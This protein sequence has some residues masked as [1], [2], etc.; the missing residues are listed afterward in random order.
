VVLTKEGSSQHKRVVLRLRAAPATQVAT[1]LQQFFAAEI[2]Q[3]N[4]T[5]SE[6][7]G[8][9]GKGPLTREVAIAAEPISNSLLLGGPADA[10]EQVAKLVEQLDQPPAMVMLEVVLGE[11]P[12]DVLSMK[13]TAET[14]PAANSAMRRLME[15]PERMEVVSRARLVTLDNQPA[16][17]EI[18]RVEG[19]ITGITTT[20]FGQ[21]N[22]VTSRNVGTKVQC[23]PRVGDDGR[24][25]M[26]IDVS[27]S[28]LGAPGEGVVIATPKTG[29]PIRAP[30]TEQF[31]ALTTLCVPSGQT[32]VVSGHGKQPKPG[33]DLI[34][35]VT[36]HVLRLDGVKIPSNPPN[37][38]PKR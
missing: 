25:T 35:L 3:S 38:Q 28:G 5:A 22:S 10:V 14:K 16:Y 19:V 33:K 18:G 1:T 21:T 24:V 15:K 31:T 7:G 26:D 20:A 29:E 11:A 37:K 4:A 17:V 12:A 36:P 34:L 6:R 9:P 8:T 23:I 2:Q 13:P 32:V 30:N 27:Y